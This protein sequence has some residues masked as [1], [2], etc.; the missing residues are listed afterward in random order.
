MVDVSY[1]DE[2]LRVATSLFE[3]ADDP[4]YDR[5]Q[6]VL[7]R[8]AENPQEA[9]YAPWTEFISSRQLYGTKIPGGDW[10]VF[11]RID[12]TGVVVILLVKDI[13]L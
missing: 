3:A 9:R 10:T 13:G 7:D 4:T 5:L 11:W 12:E 8:I 1:S 2:A 6:D